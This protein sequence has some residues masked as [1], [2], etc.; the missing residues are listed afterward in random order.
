M[1]LCK[2]VFIKTKPQLFL[3]PVNNTTQM[4]SFDLHLSIS[5]SVD[6]KFDPNT[7]GEC[8]KNSYNSMHSDIIRFS[9]P[10]LYHTNAFSD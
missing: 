8:K 3:F 9:A 7:K 6:V 10:K 2:G 5:V 4:E 1:L